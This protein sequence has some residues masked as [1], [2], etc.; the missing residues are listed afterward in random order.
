MTIAFLMHTDWSGRNCCVSGLDA[1]DLGWSEW[2]LGKCVEK[3]PGAVASSP[4]GQEDP[5]PSTVQALIT[6]YKR[7]KRDTKQ[8]Y[9]DLHLERVT[10]KSGE[11]KTRVLSKQ[12]AVQK[13]IVNHSFFDHSLP[14][15]EECVRIKECVHLAG[16][17]LTISMHPSEIHMYDCYLRRARRYLE[18]GAG[19]ST[20]FAAHH[21]NLKQMVTLD[22]S[23]QWLAKL[24]G[25]P[26][27]AQGVSSGRIDL[28]RIDIGPTQAFMG[29]PLNRK[30]KTIFSRYSDAIALLAEPFDLILVDGRFRAGCILKV[31]R[32]YVTK[33]WG[34]PNI[35]FHDYMD[36]VDLSKPP[37]SKGFSSAL[38][39]RK[40]KPVHLWYN[41]SVIEKYLERVQ[42]ADR[43]A[44]FIIRPA[45]YTNSTLMAELDDD[46]IRVHQDWH[47]L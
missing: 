30:N 7:G 20:E 32:H 1:R 31:A 28:L 4:I 42:S 9:E 11:G 16:M 46:I 37:F 8:R 33:K 17:V 19:G 3:D 41:A 24:A 15:V 6:R 18:W 12:T 39:Q 27:I 43:L 35:L 10:A 2:S 22:S 44:G 40:S 45:V 13:A 5:G 36:R 25:T 34:S 14:R 23:R 47:R 38:S 29:K 21:E 26:L